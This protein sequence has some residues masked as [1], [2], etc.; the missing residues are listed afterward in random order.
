MLPLLNNQRMIGANKWPRTNLGI[1]P[2]LK[3][4]TQAFRDTGRAQSSMLRLI[5]HTIA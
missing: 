2:R 4:F 1:D 3:E 5:G